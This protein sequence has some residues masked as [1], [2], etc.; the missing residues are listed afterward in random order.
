MQKRKKNSI[1]QNIGGSAL[2]FFMTIGALVLLFVLSSSIPKYTIRENLLESAKYLVTSE[3]LFHQIK[4]GDRRTEIHNYADATTLNILYSIDGE[5]RIKEI[6]ISPFYSAEM[7]LSKPV[8]ALLV[9]RITYERAA[10]TMYDRYWHGMNIILRPLL[11]FFSVIQIRWIFLGMLLALMGLL[12]GM[13]IKRKQKLSAVLVWLSGAM[14]QLPM[15]AFCFEYFPVFLLTFLFAVV[16]VKWE[17]NREVIQKLCI[18]NGTCIAFFDFL[19]TETVAFVIPMAMVYCIWNS[20]E[21]LR[22]IK[23]ELFYIIQAGG[24]WLGSYIMTYLIKWGLASLVYGKERFSVALQQFA[25]RQGNMV[26]SYAVDSMENGMVS[27]EAMANA[28]GH[29]LPQFLSAVVLN[30]RLLLGLSGKISLESLALT[31]LL[32]IFVLAAVVYLFRKPDK[33][34]TL[35]ILL[36]LLGM[37]PMLRMMVLHNHSIEHCFFVYRALYG[38]IFCFIAGFMKVVDWEF[39]QRRK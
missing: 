12:T 37:L 39:L 28:G 16:M 10:D 38:T 36:F 6:L 29:I 22:S 24:L 9:E 1:G 14:V 20:K 3:D 30:I 18:V 15:V 35:S 2:W 26:L 8:T 7:D 32:V 21:K 23:E 25:G 4:P 34:G 5:E 19:T 33:N 27:A 13:L 11:L 31:L 17:E